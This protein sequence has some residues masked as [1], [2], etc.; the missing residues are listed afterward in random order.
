[1]LERY[2]FWIDAPAMRGIVR[3]LVGE[4]GDA[5]NGRIVWGGQSPA[6]HV[7]PAAWLEIQWR[8]GRRPLDSEDDVRRFFHEDL[9]Q[10]GFTPVRALGPFSRFEFHQ[11]P[12]WWVHAR[13]EF[14]QDQVEW[15]AFYAPEMDRTYAIGTIVVLPPVGIDPHATLRD[16]FAVFPD[17]GASGVAPKPLPALLPSPEALAPPLGARFSGPDPVMLTWS[18][19][20]P[21]ADDEYFD[22]TVDYNYG[23][24]NPFLHLTTRQ[25]KVILPPG[26]YDTPNCSVFNWQVRV[27][28]PGPRAPSGARPEEAIS[29]AS[30]YQYLLWYHPADRPAS[31]APHCPNAQY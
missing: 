24:G 15:I 31:F 30:F 16:S 10:F 6:Q 4:Y 3:S 1:M 5:E 29:Y 11:W 13:G 12:A 23:E 22:V 19:F 7:L 25:T 18:W 26:L 27:M 2:G 20:R 21:L 9:G 28:R 8:Q 17:L 14:Q